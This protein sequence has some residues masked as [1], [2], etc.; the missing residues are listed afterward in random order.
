LRLGFSI[1]PAETDNVN[2]GWYCVPKKMLPDGSSTAITRIGQS[3]SEP[4]SVK[5]LAL[6]PPQEAWQT[7][8]WREGSGHPL[9]S[10]FAR[11]RVRAAHRDTKLHQPRAEEW[12][13]I[14]WPEDETEPTKYWFATLPEDVAFDRLVDLA[15]LRWRIERDYLCQT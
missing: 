12:W 1:N 6:S 10:R 9:S 14:E 2:S 3:C 11:Q 7:V 5:A 4:I 8:A 13:L 15:K